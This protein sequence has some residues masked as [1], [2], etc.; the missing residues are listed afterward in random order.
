MVVATRMTRILP[1]L[2]PHPH[3]I[4]NLQSPESEKDKKLTWSGVFLLSLDPLTHSEP[5]SWPSV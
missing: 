5:E 1:N 4:L 3:P 2:L